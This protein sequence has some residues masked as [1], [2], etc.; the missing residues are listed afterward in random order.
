MFSLL[1]SLPL[2]RAGGVFIMKCAEA[3]A[4]KRLTSDMS[5]NKAMMVLIE[6]ISSVSLLREK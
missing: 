4:K 1:M 6:M 2:P 3:S 5:L